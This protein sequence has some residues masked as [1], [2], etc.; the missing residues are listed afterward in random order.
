[1]EL[2]IMDILKNEGVKKQFSFFETM[3]GN[4]IEFYGEKIN[5]VKPVKIEGH[6][7]NYEGKIRLVINISTEIERTCSRCLAYY[8]EKIDFDADY[9]FV[10]SFENS[11]EDAYLLKGDTISLDEIVLDEIASQM[12]MKPLCK[13]NCKGLCPKCGKNK[14]IDECGCVLDEIDPRLQILSSFLEKN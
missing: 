13:P 11:K 5:I 7:I 10:K 9:V 6:A 3:Q 4:S 2:N 12:T 8:Y 14:N 1:M